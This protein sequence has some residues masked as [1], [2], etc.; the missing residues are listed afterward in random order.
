MK[1]FIGLILVI[2]LGF[3][4]YKGAVTLSQQ[5]RNP[6]LNNYYNQNAVSDTGVANIVT[7]IVLTYRGFDTLGEVTVL[8][9]AALGVGVLAF[10]KKNKKIKESSF[11]IK[12]GYKILFPAILLYGIYIFVH[13]HLTP[14][15]G[16]QGGA[17]IASAFL[18]QLIIGEYKMSS[19]WAALFEG[20]SGL[21]FILLGGAGLLW[22]GTFLGNKGLLPLGTVK[23][24]FSAG[25]IPIIYV[26][27]GIKV[28]FEMTGILNNL[29][30]E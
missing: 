14:G 4:L 17:I 16:F 10:F 23:M 11:I 19:A 12:T 25:I 27:I 22:L 13:G 9:L 3:F 7:S 18:L 5:T 29:N 26:F 20:F 6:G 15:G 1:K 28:G 8:F 24:L 2:I 30:K 21:V